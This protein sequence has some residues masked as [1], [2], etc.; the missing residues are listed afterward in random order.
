MKRIERRTLIGA[1]LGAGLATALAGK[2]AFAQTFPTKQIRWIIPFAPGGNYDVTSRI[3]AEPMGR[4]LGQ[5]IL[6]DNKPGAGGVVGLELA[7]NAPA[8]GYT[9]VMASFTVGYVAPI[10][11]GKKEMLSQFAPVS[12]LTT[13][14]TLVVVRADSRFTDM[15]SLLAEAKAKPGT[16]SIGHSG[17]GTTNH[18]SI[19]RLQLNEQP[20][21]QHHPL[22]RLGPR[23]RRSAGGQ[24]RQLCRPA[25]QLDAA[26]Q[27]R[28]AS[29]AGELRP[30]AHSRATRRA[31]HGRSRHTSRSMAPRRPACS[32]ISTRPRP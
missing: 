3:V 11:A 21:V 27:V 17:N 8:D 28:Q 15:K 14:P 25:H 31:D 12:I 13:V 26:H 18:V 6:I 5:S 7:Y 23:H 19:L 9:I 1:G 20:E 10:F 4:Q 22:S 29:A 2:A 32:P 16:V 30:G 24:C